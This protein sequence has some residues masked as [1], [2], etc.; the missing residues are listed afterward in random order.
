MDRIQELIKTLALTPHPEGG[1]YKE[2]YRSK[3]SIA[4]TSLPN[5]FDGAR[6]YCTSIYFLLPSDSFSA[7]HKIKQ[8]EIWNYHEGSALQIHQISPEGIYSYVILGNNLSLGQQFQHV[9]PANYWFAA[10]V[11]QQNSYTLVGCTVAPGFDFNDFILANRQQLA[12]KFPQ[13]KAIINKLTQS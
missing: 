1:Y 6:N 11:I 12:T 5:E 9:V 8:D 13:H 3:G 7:F 2:T 10:T 4:K